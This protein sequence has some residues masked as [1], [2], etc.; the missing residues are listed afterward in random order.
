ML[1][2]D[3]LSDCTRVHTPAIH[4]FHILPSIGI[5]R[6]LKP[7]PFCVMYGSICSSACQLFSGV[8]ALTNVTPVCIKW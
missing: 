3:F 2:V 6:L 4:E 5:F 7:E 1:Y 8:G